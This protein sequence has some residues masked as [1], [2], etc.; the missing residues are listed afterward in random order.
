MGT[1]NRFACEWMLDV[2]RGGRL[3]G[4][5]GGP[6]LRHDWCGNG[7]L[8]LSHCVDFASECHPSP[9]VVRKKEVGKVKW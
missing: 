8:A 4:G 2:L 6:T 3:R 7:L 1:R 9:S 5:G